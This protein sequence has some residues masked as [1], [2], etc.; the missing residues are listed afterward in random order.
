MTH[1]TLYRQRSTVV[2]STS[3]VLR[4]TWGPF[5]LQSWPVDQVPEDVLETIAVMDLT[6]ENRGY[7]E[8][9]YGTKTFEHQEGWC[10]WLNGVACEKLRRFLL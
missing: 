2:L 7:P 3:A 10:Y 4:T 8:G 9:P 5:K 6:E 1:L